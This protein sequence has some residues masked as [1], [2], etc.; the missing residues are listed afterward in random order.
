MKHGLLLLFEQLEDY[1]ILQDSE[2]II[3]SEVNKTIIIKWLNYLVER[4]ILYLPAEVLIP[5]FVV[6]V[7]HI[8]KHAKSCRALQNQKKTIN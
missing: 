7:L 5:D 4:S 2:K 6:L 3:I 1:R 8:F